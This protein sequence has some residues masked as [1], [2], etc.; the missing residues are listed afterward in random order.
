M[1]RIALS[2]AILLAAGQ[3]SAQL[4]QGLSPTPFSAGLRLLSVFLLI[5]L[6][7]F[8]VA[9]EFSVVSVRRSRI[10]QLVESGDAQAKTV[11]ELQAHLDRLLST[12]QLGITL[13]SLALGWI[14]E[15]TIAVLV[16]QAIGRLPLSAETINFLSHSLSIPIGFFLLAY[17]QIVLGELFPKS[18]ALMYAERMA[19]VLGQPSRAIARVFNPFL[20]VLGQ[21]TRL[22]LRL[23]GIRYS[24]QGWYDRVTP[25]ELQL[26][27]ATERESTGLEAEERELL[28]NVFKFGDVCAGDVM[29]PR[30][31]IQSLPSDATFQMLLEEMARSGH[32]RYPIV[33]DSLDDILG[34]LDF[35]DLVAPLAEERLPL[36]AILHPWIRP[37]RFIPESAP[38]SE[39]L[40]LMQRSRS[41][42]FPYP[43]MTI[44]VDEFGGTA[45]LLTL[46]DAIAEIVGDRSD[47]DPIEDLS[48]QILDDRTFLV[49]AQMHLEEIN[50]LLDLDLPLIDEYQTIGGFAIYHLQKIPEAGET[51]F[52]QDIE[53]TAIAT[54]GPRI[55]RIQIRRRPPSEPLAE[56]NG[57]PSEE[58]EIILEEKTEEL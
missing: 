54:D 43:E 37:A 56:T 6:N 23:V 36:D 38:L 2:I 19:K 29:V 1:S 12:T 52:Y 22:L 28:G 9:A 33:G 3:G 10:H 27:V 8:F 5:A 45:G 34:I 41:S 57:N 44:V 20:W 35:K 42:N 11:Q 25:E 15:K 55:E 7:A 39:M 16:A 17:L 47:S 51:F 31:Q 58:A 50:E 18:I 49:Q 24:S 14:G 13:S 30:T 26:I 21:S 53:L 32:S 40:P 46:Q 4:A 48:V